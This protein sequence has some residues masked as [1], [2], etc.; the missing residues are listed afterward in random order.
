MYQALVESGCATELVAYPR[1]GHGL[2]ERDHVLDAWDRI[3][4]WTGTP[5]GLAGR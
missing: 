5:P 4:D 3:K 1:E 2:M